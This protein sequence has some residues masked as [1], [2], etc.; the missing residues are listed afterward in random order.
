MSLPGR[1]KPNLQHLAPEAESCLTGVQVPP[2]IN[3]GRLRVS[4]AARFWEKVEKTSTCWNWKA[5]GSPIGYGQFRY[6]GR[7]E[8]AHRVAYELLRG[9]IPAGLEIDHLCRNRACVRPD[10]LET[11]T[12]QVNVAR[13]VTHKIAC[14]NGHPFTKANTRRNARGRACRECGALAARFWR[15]RAA[16][17]LATPRSVAWRASAIPLPPVASGVPS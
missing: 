1:C 6:A 2:W 9:P 7:L 11:V 8:G 12:H 15:E 17:R 3:R 5:S 14:K 4:L 16:Q 13:R 10:H